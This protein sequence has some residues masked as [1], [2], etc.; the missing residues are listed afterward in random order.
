[1]GGGGGVSSL[2]TKIFLFVLLKLKYQQVGRQTHRQM[3]CQTHRPH[4]SS[5]T[6]GTQTDMHTEKVHRQSDSIP[7][8]TN[9]INTDR[10]TDKHTKCLP[11]Q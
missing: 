10:Q 11:K 6:T 7:A 3:H 9:T 8:S 1:M 2:K 4:T 5:D